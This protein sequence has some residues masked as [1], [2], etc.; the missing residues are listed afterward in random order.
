MLERLSNSLL[1]SRL[2]LF[3]EKPVTDKFLGTYDPTIV[4]LYGDEL[5]RIQK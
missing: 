1:Q 5:G 2:P 4:E 3:R